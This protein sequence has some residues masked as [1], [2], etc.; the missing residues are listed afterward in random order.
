[1]LP[2]EFTDELGRARFICYRCGSKHDIFEVQFYYSGG[3]ISR[4]SKRCICHGCVSNVVELVL[5]GI[6]KLGQGHLPKQ[7]E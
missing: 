6:D 3:L 4:E 1:M 5:D 7:S 2:G